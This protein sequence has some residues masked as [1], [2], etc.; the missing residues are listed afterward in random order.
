[1]HKSVGW[2]R[3]VA[4]LTQPVHALVGINPDDRARHGGFHHY[5]DTQVRDLELRRAGISVDVL[6]RKPGTII[7]QESTA[8]GRYRRLQ[9][10]ASIHRSSFISYFAPFLRVDL[11]PLLRFFL[12]GPVVELFNLG[13]VPFLS[14]WPGVYLP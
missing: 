1:E 4:D 13:F 8:E 12:L 11:Y 2:A 6:Q 7:H 14:I 10:V 5:G 3:G 9:Q